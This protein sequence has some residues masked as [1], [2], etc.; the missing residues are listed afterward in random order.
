MLALRF[1]HLPQDGAFGSYQGCMKTII[2][3]FCR[4]AFDGSGAD[5]FFDAGSCIVS[6]SVGG[7]KEMLIF[8]MCPTSGPGRGRSRMRRVAFDAPTSVAAGV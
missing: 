3:D 4:H 8:V 1:A 7:R 5:N 2:T 6:T